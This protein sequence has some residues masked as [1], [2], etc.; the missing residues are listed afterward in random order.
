MVRMADEWT[1]D[2]LVRRAAQALAAADVRVSNG[3]VTGVPDGRLIRWYATIG[4]IDRPGAM[5]G[6]TAL[7]GP[8]HLLQ[9]VAVKRRQAE[10]KA[11][12]DI[13]WELTGATDAALRHVAGIS[14]EILGDGHVGDGHVTASD[15]VP[16]SSPDR[17]D[18]AAHRST[19]R[20]TRRSAGAG[21][22]A[23]AG[24][25]SVATGA[26]EAE[27][28]FWAQPPVEQWTN[29]DSVEVDY[30]QAHV[31]TRRATAPADGL[32]SGVRLGN[33]AI[34]LLPTTPTA[35]DLAAIATAAQPLL[36][37]LA[38]RGIVSP[39]HQRSEGASV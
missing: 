9:L 23:G 10:G 5:R 29:R 39:S 21:A 12:A 15:P 18:A 7:Y 19:P 4:L 26:T 2:E 36:D 17:A 32:L 37:L 1:L 8:R 24:V 35:A 25:E 20:S 38:A 13:Q 34:L 31:D 3:R 6:R 30:A 22:G 16:D 33:G 27:A 14:S 11:L 28:R